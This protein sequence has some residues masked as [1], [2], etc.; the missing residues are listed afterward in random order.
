MKEIIPWVVT[1]E[2]S[3]TYQVCQC[4]RCQ[5]APWADENCPKK[6]DL[7]FTRKELIWLCS[8][9]ASRTMPYCDGTH[10]PRNNMT[11]MGAIKDLWNDL[12]S[13]FRK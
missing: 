6:I 5:T 10:N 8:C 7:R 3:T 9:G 13:H 4:L 1:V 12:M 11:V 2:P